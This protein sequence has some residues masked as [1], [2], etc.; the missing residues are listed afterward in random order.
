MLENYLKV[1]LKKALAATLWTKTEEEAAA[2]IS[3]ENDSHISYGLESQKV[4]QNQFSVN[5]LES[6]LT[7]VK[8]F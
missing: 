8:I 4:I 7:T 6:D 1:N 2:A 5:F 3:K